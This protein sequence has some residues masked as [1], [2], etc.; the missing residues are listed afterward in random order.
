MIKGFIIGKFMPFHKGHEALIEYAKSNC[1]HLTI[2]VGY[3]EGEPIPLKYR[4]HW[5]SSA[6]LHDPKIEVKG[7]TI[8]HP[9]DLSFDDLS[10][11]WAKHILDN[12]GQFSRVF[13]SEDYGKHFANCMNAENW[14][15]N[16]SRTIIPI[17]ATIIRQ[18]PHTYWDYLNS[19]A[20][21]Y[22]VKKIAIV[23]TESTGKTI[24]CERLAKHYNTLWVPELG[25]QMIP[26]T[27]ECSFDDLKWVGTAH[28]KT[29]LT[30]VRSANKVLFV[31]TD[32]VI[33][34]SYAKHLFNRE[35][36]FPWWVEDANKMDLHI[37]LEQNAPYVDD[38]TR[39][40]VKE[41]NILS[42]THE[43]GFKEAG[44]KVKSFDYC[45]DYDVRLQNVIDY[46][47]K[48]L[49]KF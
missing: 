20:K 37:F 38:G 44:I 10:A 16:E 19:Y 22:F 39:L 1:D 33:T 13:S 15:F 27:R 28:A 18:K 21:D 49:S 40:P 14:V 23:G 48:F 26:D 36:N 11:W 46:I 45:G 25:R 2:L 4:L 34:K 47:D 6:Y 32:M 30:S 3:R 29:I 41:R 35:L 12:Y 43:K 5:V 7:D 17:S 8:N 24:M 31:D 42:V 9:T